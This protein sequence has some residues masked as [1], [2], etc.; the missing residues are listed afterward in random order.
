M[1]EKFI[2][3]REISSQNQIGF[4]HRVCAHIVF[5]DVSQCSLSNDNINSE[6]A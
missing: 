1:Q 3:A 4:N 5:L 2:S 6:L